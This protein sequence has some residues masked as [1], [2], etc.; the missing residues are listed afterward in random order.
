M[1]RPRKKHVQ[2]TFEFRT[3]G[4]KRPGAGRPPRGASSS[5]PHKERE[6]FNPRHP[7]HITTRVL[8]DVGSLRKRDIY[9]AIREATVTVFERE[10]FHIV[11]FAILRNHLHM[12]VEAT[13][14]DALASGLQV[15]LSVA[16]RKINRA[17]WRRT[18]NRRRGTVFADRYDMNE[19][20]SPR[21]VRNT[22]CYVLNN[23]RR[24]QE[25]RSG[26]AARWKIDP[27][28]TGVFFMDWAELGDSPTMY[29]PPASY[30]GLMTWLPQTWL[31]RVGWKRHGPISYAEVPGPASWKKRKAS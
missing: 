10:D 1:A 31:L 8:D 28:S 11:H 14:N 21:Q 13:G 16:A 30:F 19:L 26:M 9:H 17:I 7:L 6:E 27:F 15:L 20:T 2:Q 25:D 12:L 23:W 3:R 22:I 5:E 29:R 4:G 24:H 18:G